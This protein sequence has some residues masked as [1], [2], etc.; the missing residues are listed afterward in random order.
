MDFR[1]VFFFRWFPDN[2]EHLLHQNVIKIRTEA[3]CHEHRTEHPLLAAGGASL[4][5]WAR[6]YLSEIGWFRDSAAR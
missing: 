5:G 2:R 1:T 6:G 4:V 3:V